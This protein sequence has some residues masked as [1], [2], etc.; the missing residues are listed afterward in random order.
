MDAY[1]ERLI[2]RAATIDELLSDD[3][4]TLPGQKSDAELT[5]RRLSAW[6]RSSASGDW[7]LFGRRLERDGLSM[8]RVRARLATVRRKA[9]VD[10]PPWIDDAI[11]IEAALHTLAKG[12]KPSGRLDRAEAYP[13][14]S[15]FTPLVE[16]AEALLWSHIDAQVFE[17]LTESARA[18]LCQALLKE[19]SGLCTPAIYERFVKAR[20]AGPTPTDIADLKQ[21]TGTTCYDK[22][23]A[24]MKAGEFRNL[25]EEKPVLL[26]LMATIARQWIDTS[27]EFVLRLDADIAAI[28]RDLLQSGIDGRVCKIEG[29]LADPHNGGRS[30][31]IISFEDGGRVVYKPKDLRL[32][33]AW[34]ALVERLNRA[35]P[36]LTLTAVRPIV[37]GGYGWTGFVDHTGCADQD[38][39]S[40][41]FQRAGA[42]LALFHCFAATDMH[43]ENLIAASDHPVPID[44]ETILR[45]T[46]EVDKD[47]DPEAQA[48]DAARETV[49]NSVMMVGLLPAY[50]RGIDNNVFA[51]GGMT[52]DWN[53]KIKIKWSDIN[54][55]AMRPSK[56]KKAGK[57]MPNLPHVQGHYAKFS[58]YIE[59]FIA[60]FTDYAKFLLHWRRDAKQSDLFDGFAGVPVRTVIRPTRFYYMLLQRLKNHGAMEDGVVWS[61]QAD[62]IARLADWEK[63]SDPLWKLHLAERTALLTLNVPHFVTPSDGNETR[64]AAGISIRTEVSSGLDRARDRVA[65]FDAQ[66]IDWQIT[67]IRQNTNAIAGS[68]APPKQVL[69]PATALA[70]PKELFAAQA[71]NTAEELSR[72]AIRRGPGAAWIGLDWLGDS[73][74]FQLVC[75]GPELYNGVAG[76]AVFLAA[77]AAVT[78]A[79]SSRELAL[80]GISHLRKDLR[81]RNAARMAR[82]LGVGGATGLGSIVY[83][84]C[85]MS[86]SLQDAGLLADA[87]VAAALFT[88]ELIAADKQLDIIG[89]SAGGV[90]GLLRLYRDTQSSDALKRAVKCGEHLLAQ[91]RVG[92]E[93]RRSWSGQG[94]GPLGL[95]GMSHGAAGFAFALASLSA[96]SGHEEF[97]RAASECIAFENA[98][99]DAGHTNW[100]DLRVEGEPS[101]P[102]Q[103]CHGAPGIGLARIAMA[104][105]S[106]QDPERLQADI[107]NALSGVERGWV[108]QVDTLCCGTL[109]SIEFFCEAGSALGRSDLVEL[110]SRRLATVFETAKSAGDFR[111][112]SGNR[113]FNLGLFRGLSGVGYTSLRQIDG[114]LPNVLIWE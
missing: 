87:Q 52:H 54:T 81:G 68:A 62:F 96:A 106:G 10:P 73:E 102:C 77:H 14:E 104:K 59:D 15:L 69:R 48:F 45:A 44:L 100:P 7:S 97:A 51:V 86:K 37:R 58:D 110:A 12:T 82:S 70:P 61:A 79:R 9:S 18:C 24:A 112:N 34:Y 19:L 74:N 35:D 71:D 21:N 60:G 4:E 31:Q 11:W 85:V 56:S 36:P 95:N 53:F 32:D 17:R 99:Y 1:Y 22:F 2:V 13:F 72:Y 76:I 94:S 5:E 63:D 16:Q 91:D 39:C 8:D 46:T 42:W 109:G 88:D 41:Y 43:Q 80:A 33:A 98:S 90:L 47:Q 26:R 27:R 103:W 107:K 50:G 25:F 83:A 3:F 89:G 49:A 23:V 57:T 38:G 6:C 65:R 67:V 105:Q 66:D 29:E 93:G 113:Q 28:R 30:V 108:G 75:L 92:P 55:D 111:W 84:L 114:S 64:D 78:G 101:W 40:R 20:K